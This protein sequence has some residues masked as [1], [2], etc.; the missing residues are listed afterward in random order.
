MNVSNEILLEELE[1]VKHYIEIT[2]NKIDHDA[3]R[4]KIIAVLNE[5]I[6][7]LEKYIDAT[8]SAQ[9]LGAE[10]MMDVA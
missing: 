9:E 4:D 5:R 3:T 6:I 8:I 10:M 7:E 2:N 1:A